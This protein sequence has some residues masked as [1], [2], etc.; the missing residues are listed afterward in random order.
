[1]NLTDLPALNA[2]LNVSSLVL[3][4]NGYRH[5]KA[6][7][8]EQHRRSML[9]AASCSVLFLVSYLVYHSAVGSVRFTADGW[10]RPV[11]F[12]V[13]ISH[14]VLAAVLAPMALLTLWRGWTGRFDAHRSIARK[15]FP[16]WVYVSLTGVLVYVMLYHLY[17]PPA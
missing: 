6:G 9:A 8:K 16:L 1:M 2:L 7:R 3:L 11:Y 15:T 17:P 14:T 10:V 5:I 12:A 4:L 13:L